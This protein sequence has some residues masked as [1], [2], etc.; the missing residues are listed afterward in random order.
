MILRTTKPRIVL[1]SSMS[2]ASNPHP[3]VVQMY[4]GGLPISFLRFITP[5]ARLLLQQHPP[6]FVAAGALRVEGSLGEP[7]GLTVARQEEGL[8][9]A[10]L[11]S[12]CVAESNQ[13]QGI[14]RRLLEE[15]E[16][17]LREKGTQTVLV[18]YLE[19]AEPSSG[20][21]AY[22]IASGYET[23]KPG[24][25]VWS[26]PVEIIRSY[27]FFERVQLPDSFQIAPW[28]TL[29]DA[30]RMVVQKGLGDWVPSIL[31]PFDD[32][33]SIDPERS[34]VLRHR[35]EVVGWML[36]ET[37]DEQTVLFKTMFV[38]RRYQRRGRGIALIAEACRR[39]LEEQRFTHGYFF[40]EAQNQ[41]MVR[42]M[43]AHLFHPDMIR[44]VLW[45]T[46]K[47]L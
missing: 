38:H 22:L 40:V 16:G 13:R 4:H 31:S 28:T 18:E 15:L 43:N 29:T 8:S 12:V 14:G 21:D 17:F 9:V 37:F 47:N 41:D 30:E 46:V 25:L 2:Q 1:S 6:S 23:P 24:T 42:F 7:V 20:V 33:A 5:E 3:V 35:G 36:V 39:V 10:H 27:S 44:E 32:E 11:L 45:R 34:L 26:G 19:H